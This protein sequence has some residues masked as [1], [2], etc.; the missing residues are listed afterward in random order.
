MGATVLLGT[1]AKC[2]SSIAEAII[3]PGHDTTQRQ[4]I[5]GY[6][7][8]KRDVALDSEHPYYAE[9]PGANAGAPAGMVII[10]Q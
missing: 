1:S 9:A 2:G 8:W 4:I 10:V 3:V 5:E 6:L 7:A